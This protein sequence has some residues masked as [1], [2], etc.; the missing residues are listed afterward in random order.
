MLVNKIDLLPHLDFDLERAL[1]GARQV[2]PDMPVLRLSARTGEGMEQW[3]D[4]LRREAKAA[5]EAA[6]A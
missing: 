5:S 3:Y 1:D 4:W 2:N 6:F